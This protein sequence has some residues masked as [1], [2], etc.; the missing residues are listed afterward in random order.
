MH[1]AQCL[2]EDQGG[3]APEPE[4]SENPGQDGEPQPDPVPGIVLEDYP[5]VYEG[6]AF[7]VTYH[8][9]GVARLET[10]N[11]P[12]QPEPG[13]EPGE[14]APSGPDDP[15][16][17]GEPEPAPTDEP[18]PTQE[19]EPAVPD[20]PPQ[21]VDLGEE[22]IDIPLAAKPRGMASNMDSEPNAELPPEDGGAELSGSNYQR[23]PLTF[24]APSEQASG[25]IIARNS[26]AAAFPRPST[27]WGTWTYSA[28]HT[29]ASSGE[30]VYIKALTE[31]VEIKRGYMP[32]I[33]EGAVEVGLN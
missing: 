11:L 23:G 21:E 9:S 6:E 8:I 13:G 7:T 27:P 5:F 28:I 2:E 16:Q 3:E 33:A 30:P 20:Q 12:D 10:E 17:T 29:A 25:Q 24:G 19:P 22:Y 26:A 15:A 14:P 1:T 31:A 18:I 32:T 4:E